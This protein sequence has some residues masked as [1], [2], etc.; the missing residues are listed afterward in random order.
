M[1]I[2]VH[3]GGC[4]IVDPFDAIMVL[5]GGVKIFHDSPWG[6]ALSRAGISILND[7][8]KFIFHFIL[9]TGMHSRL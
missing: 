4:P 3:N 8:K 2:N 7:D 1:R 9:K 5:F 6:L